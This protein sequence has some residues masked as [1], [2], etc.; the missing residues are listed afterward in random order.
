V[1]PRARVRVP[2]RRDPPRHQ[3][4]NILLSR[5]GE[6]KVGDFGASFQQFAHDDHADHRRRLAGYM[7]P[8]QIRM[9]PLTHQ[10]DIYSLGV[11]MY[12]CS[13]GGCRSRPHAGVA[14]LRDPQHRPPRPP[15]LRPELPVLLDRS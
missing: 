15:T 5:A 8:E 9:E 3:A 11:T 12:R 14:V 6:T 10:T 7:S 2:A 1:H 4:G 13:P